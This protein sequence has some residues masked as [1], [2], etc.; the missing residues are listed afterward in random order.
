MT[1]ITPVIF[2]PIA[3]SDRWNTFISEIMSNDQERADFL[4][5]ILGYALS[6]DT[7]H[8]CMS[9][10]Y[11]ATTRNGK[12]TLCESVLKVFGSYGCTA[13]P[14]TIA[15]KNNTNSS[16][17]SED[18]ARLAGVRFVNIAEPGKS[19]VLNAALVK[20]MT[21]NDTLNARFL[22]EN[23]FD[24]EPQFKLYINT[25]YLP[26]VNDMTV[27]SSGRVIIIPFERH[28]DEA[29]QDKGLKREFAAPTVQSAILNWLIEGFNQLYRHGL[30]MPQSVINATRQY[31][32]DSNKTV[33]FIEDCMEEG[34][35][36]E[37]RTSDVYSKYKLWCME[38]GQYAESMKNF[39]Q[40]LSAVMEVKRKRPKS[41]GEKTTVVIGYRLVSEFLHG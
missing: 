33:L 4:Q 16:Q 17:P 13:R 2:D 19:L 31:Q 15:Q 37:E 40:S 36:Y 18:I 26:V 34:A 8:E 11:G 30:H 10:L 41:G 27:F 12:G 23:S 22:H 7:R 24:F 29:D 25:N 32:H 39:K 6:G 35:D 9:I 28:F 38:N 20:N 5:K 21:G 1:K 3:H 14:E